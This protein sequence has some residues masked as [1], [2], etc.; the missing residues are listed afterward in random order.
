MLIFSLVTVEKFL[1]YFQGFPTGETPK[2]AATFIS[3]FMEVKGV[4]PQSDF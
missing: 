3:R 4:I 1:H 2:Q